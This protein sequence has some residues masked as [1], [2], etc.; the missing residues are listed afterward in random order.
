[1]AVELLPNHSK[2]L[3]PLEAVYDTKVKF[4]DNL[5]LRTAL[6]KKEGIGR[7]Y[8]P[9]LLLLEET[10]SNKIMAIHIWENNPDHL[11]Q[12]TV[13]VLQKYLDSTCIL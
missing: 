11:L 4:N 7:E 10:I 12:F 13:R 3:H 1:M 6:W 9:D 5:V 2:C 8:P